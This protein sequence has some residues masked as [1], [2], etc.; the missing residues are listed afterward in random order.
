MDFA[1]RVHPA[2]PSDPSLDA[3][4]LLLQG[5]S[6]HYPHSQKVALDDVSYTFR[7][8][9]TAIVGPNGAGKSTLVKLVTG[10]LAP[11]AGA[12]HTRLADGVCVPAEQLPKAV[13]FQEPSHLY[14]TVRQNVTMRYE[15]AP[16]EDP[17]IH[18]A[19]EL[20]GLGTVVAGLPDGLDTLI[21]AGFGGRVDLSG[22]QWQRLALARLIYRDAPIMILDEPVASLDPE[23]ERA[24]FELFA[25]M[26]HRIII[27]TTHRYDSIPPETPIVVLVD[28]RISEAG[29]HEELLR[30]EQDYWSLYMSGRSIARGLL[31]SHR[32]PD[33]AGAET[34][35]HGPTREVPCRP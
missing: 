4:A 35:N 22:G 30:Q 32:R 27:F 2:P 3:T 11:T 31:G 14:L 18:H 8:G 15:R 16:D 34:T 10:L 25:K 28:G 12:I 5:V 26:Q 21:G 13:L 7:T 23:G 1:S 29:T 17:R 6:Y 9:T 20:A 19:L 33:G 24:V